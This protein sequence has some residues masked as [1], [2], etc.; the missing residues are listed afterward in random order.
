LSFAAEILD[1]LGAVGSFFRTMAMPFWAALLPAGVL[2]TIVYG[3]WLYFGPFM[4]A[5]ILIAYKLNKARRSQRMEAF[6]DKTFGS[7]TKAMDFYAQN[8]MRSHP[9]QPGPEE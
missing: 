5:N 2:I 1:F 9:R 7:S 4:L 3:G 6:D 8:F